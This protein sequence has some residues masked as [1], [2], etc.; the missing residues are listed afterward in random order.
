MLSFYNNK[1][2]EFQQRIEIKDDQFNLHAGLISLK[3]FGIHNKIAG[4]TSSDLIIWLLDHG[5]KCFT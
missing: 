2:L 4:T 1:K 3:F 5:K